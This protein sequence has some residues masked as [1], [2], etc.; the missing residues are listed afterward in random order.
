MPLISIKQES[1]NKLDKI[2]LYSRETYDDVVKR[3]LNLKPRG[4]KWKK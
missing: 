1:K 2:K 3:L 4:K